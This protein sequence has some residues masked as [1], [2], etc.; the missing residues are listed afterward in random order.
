[1]IFNSFQF[2]WLFPVVFIVYWAVNTL[3]RGNSYANKINNLLLI[4]I[5]YS[6]YIQYNPIYALILLYI[7]TITYIGGGYF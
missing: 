7:T 2:I 3:L 4:I 1:M 6:I 5:S